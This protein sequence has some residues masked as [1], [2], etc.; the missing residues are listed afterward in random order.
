MPAFELWVLAGPWGQGGEV[1][2]TGSSLDNLLAL[3]DGP[4]T[5]KGPGEAGAAE[6]KTLSA[7]PP[8]PSSL[9]TRELITWLLGT[10]KMLDQKDPAFP[11][12][13]QRYWLGG[14]ESVIVPL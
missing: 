8:G 12:K 2:F 13:L 1:A 10:L 3:R 6:A 11:S 9:W 7:V 4:V 5:G 14:L